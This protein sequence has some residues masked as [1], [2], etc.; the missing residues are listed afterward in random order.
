ML[1]HEILCHIPDCSL[2]CQ[3]PLPINLIQ[4][5]YEYL[6][7][8]SVTLSDAAAFQRL[9]APLEPFMPSKL[10]SLNPLVLLSNFCLLF[11]PLTYNTNESA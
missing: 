6:P 8:R 2:Y 10:Y 4:C 11:H 3:K 7:C 5:A 1:L 9:S